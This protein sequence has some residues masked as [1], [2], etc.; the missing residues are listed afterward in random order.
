[1]RSAP[2]EELRPA[3]EHEQVI[4]GGHRQPGELEVGEGR[5]EVRRF[6]ADL[7]RWWNL[8]QG[9]A[10]AKRLQAPPVMAVSRRA[11]GF[12]LR[13]A[14]LGPCYTDRYFMLRRKA[15]SP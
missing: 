4:P 14:Q 2:R 1:M 3:D 5:L 8:H 6:V 12:D 10:V 9:L 15:C 11:F 7:E 13:E